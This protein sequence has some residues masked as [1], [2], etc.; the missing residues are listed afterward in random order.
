MHPKRW[1][2]RKKI[3]T[4]PPVIGLLENWIC[5]R[6]TEKNNGNQISAGAYA[7]KWKLNST[8]VEK[9]RQSLKKLIQHF[10]V[11]LIEKH[12]SQFR[13]GLFRWRFILMHALNLPIF[14]IASKHR[15]ASVH[16]YYDACIHVKLSAKS[17]ILNKTH[18]LTVS[19]RSLSWFYYF[20]PKWIHS[21]QLPLNSH[22][23]F[24]SLGLHSKFSM[25]HA[26][27]ATP[28]PLVLIYQWHK[29]LCLQTSTQ[30]NYF[31]WF[32]ACQRVFA[33][34]VILPLFYYHIIVT[35]CFLANVN[36]IF[37]AEEDRPMRDSCH[38]YA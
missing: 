28:M 32:R 30:L 27:L 34:N 33:L 37:T 20:L 9:R 2:S 25:P 38:L 35:R 23:L 26:K 36:V 12:W 4:I 16:L 10:E 3:K 19:L 22:S 17:F 5:W 15:C 7:W 11:P 8:W 31:K 24:L 13:E 1:R 18:C 29:F 21:P 14:L 6:Q